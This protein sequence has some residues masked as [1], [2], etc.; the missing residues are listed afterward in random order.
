MRVLVNQAFVDN[1]HSWPMKY[2]IIIII[3]SHEKILFRKIK[4]LGN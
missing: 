2:Q 4:N 1:W 3:N